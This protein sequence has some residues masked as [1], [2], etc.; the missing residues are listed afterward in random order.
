MLSSASAQLQLQTSTRPALL[1]AGVRA[2][3][4]HPHPH[5]RQMT[6]L[7]ARLAAMRLMMVTVLSLCPSP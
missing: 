2:L 4:Q 6:A 3:L 1:L 7:T 5:L